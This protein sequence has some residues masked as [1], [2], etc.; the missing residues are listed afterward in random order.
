MEKDIK[1]NLIFSK[2]RVSY[3]RKIPSNQQGFVLLSLSKRIQREIMKKLSDRELLVLIDYL[4][5]T[6][7][8]DLLGSVGKKRRKRILEKL[9]R[10][11]KEKVEFL[12]SFDP[13][14]AAG[15]MSLD[16]IEVTEDITFE[17]LSK[18]IKKHEK[19][20]GKFPVVLV[21]RDGF[22]VGEIPMHALVLA[23]KKSKIKKYIKG[24][25]SVEYD[26]EEKEVI[27]LFKEHP[28]KR[29][30]VLD[31]DKSIMGIIYSDDILSIL[32]KKSGKEL[33]NFAG[34]K[35][36]DALDSAFTKVKNRYR[37]LIINLLTA[38]LA[39]SVVGLFQKTISG[40]VLLAVYMPI[41]AGMGGNAGTQT[42]AVVVRGLAL[43]EIKPK[44]AKRVIINEIIA[45]AINGTI[46]GILVAL[47]AT[48][49]NKSPLLGLVVAFSMVINLII[50]GFFGTIIPLLMKK[51]KKDPASSATIFIT[52]ATDVFGFFVF[53]GLASLIF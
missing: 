3:F 53:L 4:D 5:P 37:W 6:R 15:M 27:D 45:G 19:K 41:V 38:F 26:K 52:T 31:K 29:I 14:T 47:A 46:N 40:Y 23:D 11:I 7:T 21:V 42:L 39:A 2:K 1:E 18:A 34:I 12:L 8:A 36:E 22:L 10:E 25:L 43:K 32:E 48:L 17:Q 33:L 20:T 9:G 49:W 16:Y 51:L 50:A 30:V 24:V 44:T 28:H 35:E 13:R